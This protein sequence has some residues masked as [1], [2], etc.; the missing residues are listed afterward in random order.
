MMIK[1]NIASVPLVFVNRNDINVCIS[2]FLWELLYVKSKVLSE[3]QGGSDLYVMYPAVL[4]YSSS[5]LTG[6]RPFRQ[7]IEGWPGWV[8]LDD[9]MYVDVTISKQLPIPILTGPGVVQ[10][11]YVT[12]YVTNTPNRRFLCT[13]YWYID[14]YGKRNIYMAYAAAVPYGYRINY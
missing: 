13:Y 11:S 12:K 9:I 7:P 1:K 4:V 10:T 14:R 8:D 5:V 2:A 6:T 3:T